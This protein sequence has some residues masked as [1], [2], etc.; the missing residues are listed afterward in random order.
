MKVTD[1]KIDYDAI[2]REFAKAFEYALN[3]LGERS[4]ELS[5]F[6]GS[7]MDGL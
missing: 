3:E 6:C 4:S 5:W 1:N 2:E 7:Q